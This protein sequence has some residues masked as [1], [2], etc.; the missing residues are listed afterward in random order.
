MIDLTY[1]PPLCRIY[2]I[3]AQS[4]ICQSGPNTVTIEYDPEEIDLN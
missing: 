3:A 1:T 2:R 4:V